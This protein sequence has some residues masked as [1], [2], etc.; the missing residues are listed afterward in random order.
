MPV[1]DREMRLE[2]L[3]LRV[4]RCVVAVVVEARLADRD[5]I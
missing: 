1:G 5:R 2:Q 4:V 3:A